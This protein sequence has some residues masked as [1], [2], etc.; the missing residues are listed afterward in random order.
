MHL[1]AEGQGKM[2]PRPPGHVGVVDGFKEVIEGIGTEIGI[3]ALAEMI[4]ELPVTAERA[5]DI[6]PEIVHAEA[7]GSLLSSGHLRTEGAP[8][9]KGEV[10]AAQGE[11]GVGQCPSGLL[12][13]KGGIKAVGGNSCRGKQCGGSNQKGQ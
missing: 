4:V 6:P 8:H 12:F 10:V 5:L 11:N 3:E 2:L 1:F 13:R 7:G 9:L